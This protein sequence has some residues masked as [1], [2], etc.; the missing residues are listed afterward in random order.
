[1][2]I[3]PFSLVSIPESLLALARKGIIRLPSVSD[4]SPTPNLA[5]DPA[6]EVRKTLLAEREGG[7]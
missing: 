1:M 7:F 5:V 3:V 6:G 2:Q 4:E